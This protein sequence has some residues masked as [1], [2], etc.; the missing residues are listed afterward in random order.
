[1]Q[2]GIRSRHLNNAKGNSYPTLIKKGHVNLCR[3]D[4]CQRTNRI[5]FQKSAN[6]LGFSAADAT[7]HNSEG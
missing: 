3:I 4:Y 1:M 2:R 5:C 7:L 6:F